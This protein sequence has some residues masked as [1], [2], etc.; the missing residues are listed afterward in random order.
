MEMWSGQAAIV[1][2]GASGLGAATA[3][4]L[5][6]WRP[7]GRGLRSERGGGPGPCGAIGGRFERVD[8]SDPGASRPGIAAVEAAFGPPRVLVNCAGIGPA[9]K[10]VS[11][12]EPH[13]PGLF[14]KVIRVNLMGSFNCASAGGGADGGGGARGARRGAG[15]DR[16][17]GLGRGL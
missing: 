8:V 5:A 13:D 16:E 6:R 7:A 15:G 4:A 14:E 10:T 3:A 11:R 9:A 17:H 12:G 2:G 1:T